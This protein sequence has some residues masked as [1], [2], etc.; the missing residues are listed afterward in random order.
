[1]QKNIYEKKNNSLFFFTNLIII[2]LI[3]IL[4]LFTLFASY[5]IYIRG[6]FI[7]SNLFYFYFI[8]FASIFIFLNSWILRLKNNF[9]IYFVIIIV[10]IGFSLYSFEL[11]MIFYGNKFAKIPNWSEERIARANQSNIEFDLR[12]R[13]EVINDFKK[14]NIS[15]NP[16]I[17]PI[18]Y[19]R[20]DEYINGIEFDKNFFFPLGS[21][22][23]SQ[24]LSCNEDGQWLIYDTDKFGFN[25]PKKSYSINEV[26]IAI[27][28]DSFAKGWCVKSD[29]NIGAHLRKKN[30]NVLNY[31]IAGSGPLLQ[32]AAFKEYVEP[33]K[34]KIVIW[35]YFMN[36]LYDMIDEIRSPLLN[37]YLSNNDF[38]QKLMDNQIFIDA[39]LKKLINNE[40]QNYS[41]RLDSIVK[42]AAFYDFIKLSNTRSLFSLIPKSTKIE[43]IIK[44]HFNI[45][46]KTQQNIDE[47]GGSLYVVYLPSIHQVDKKN[48]FKSIP[49]EY[50][51][52]LYKKDVEQN[53]KS[54]NISYL[55]MKEEVFDNHFDPLSLFPFRIEGHYNDEGYRLVSEKIIERLIKDNKVAN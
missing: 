9:K 2:F 20:T 24:T 15:I 11:Y 49:L 14:N 32:Y 54:L 42:R 41:K 16:E 27:L 38:S 34:P 21:I 52:D 28:G 43:D 39:A 17:H 36:D 55:N 7:S 1:M 19:L 18:I 45:F 6:G 47:W 30:L 46:K 25:N 26:D 31:G 29:K 3:F 44:T 10:S 4:I 35:F 5:K 23:N 50:K 37:K 12:N 51:T 40:L 53:I 48:T 33:I 22:S 8:L 13:V